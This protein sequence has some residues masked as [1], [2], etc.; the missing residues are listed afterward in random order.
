MMKKFAE[1]RCKIVHKTSSCRCE[2]CIPNDK[3][4]H[5]GYCCDPVEFGYVDKRIPTIDRPTCAYKYLDYQ[6]EDI[7]T[8]TEKI[9]TPEKLNSYLKKTSLCSSRRIYGKCQN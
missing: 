7:D 1:K 6:L 2:K 4:C 3:K 9:N 8:A 5:L